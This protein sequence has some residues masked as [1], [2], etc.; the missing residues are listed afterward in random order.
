[1]RTVL[2]VGSPKARSN[3][4]SMMVYLNARLEE[5]GVE[6]MV[7]DPQPLESTEPDVIRQS[8]QA[9][10]GTDAVVIAA[11]VYLDLPPYKTLSWLEALWQ[12]RGALEGVKPS[13]YA[14]SHSGYFEPVHKRVSLE[15]LQQFGEGMGWAW[16]GGL[17]FG[18]TSPIDGKAIED[19][20]PFVRRVRPAL[21]ELAGLI[22]NGGEI[23]QAL[24]DWAGRSPI[25]LPRRLSV[26]LMN[27]YL[28][29]ERRKHR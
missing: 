21:D 27:V 19:A 9:L 18:G 20:G 23:P 26:V 12:Q 10:R 6:V 24:A 5:A 2:F 8:I 11:P 13:L 1:M 28:R 15:A 25:P 7:I 29:W 17:A 14:I 16:R 4:R 22:A 3:T